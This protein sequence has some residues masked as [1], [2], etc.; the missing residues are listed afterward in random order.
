MAASDDTISG[1]PSIHGGDSTGSTAT[2]EKHTSSSPSPAS[3]PAPPPSEEADPT[4]RYYTLADG[5]TYAQH[6]ND[7][8]PTLYNLVLDHHASTGGQFDTVVDIGCGPGTAVRALAPR[9]RHAWGLDPSA[10]MIGAA[11]ELGGVCG[12]A[13]ATDESNQRGQDKEEEEGEKGEPIRFEISSAETLEAIP[14][15]SVDL[16]VSAAATHWFDM[17]RF[18]R[19][20]ARVLKPGGGG[21]VALWGGGGMRP[22]PKFL[23]GKEVVEEIEAVVDRFDR[24]VDAFHRPGNRLCAGLYRGLGMPWDAED[25]VSG[26]GEGEWKSAGSSVF[27]RS[28]FRRIEFGT[29]HPDALSMDVFHANG[30]QEVTLAALENVLGTT[31][32]VTRW[33]EAAANA[34]RGDHDHHHL[35]G[36]AEQGRDGDVVRTFCE[37]LRDVL[38]KAGVERTDR[39]RGG[40]LGVLLLV[41]RGED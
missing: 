31:S 9:F 1:P 22:D 36:A 20:A 17:P 11:R 3:A 18:W 5:L 23:P 32:Y 2:V 30:G 29:S 13:S 25:A 41:K 24:E 33:R 40:I 19:A 26:V 34:D 39:I 7:Y 16:I 12:G 10:G 35:A 6:R 37:G 28:T 38:E 21:T 27:D 4:F 14:D 15:H 8:H